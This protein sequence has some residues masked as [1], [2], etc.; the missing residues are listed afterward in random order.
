MRNSQHRQA[1]PA[2]ERR[3][4]LLCQGLLRAARQ[5]PLQAMKTPIFRRRRRYLM[6]S[7]AAIWRRR[8]MRSIAVLI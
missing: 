2:P 7:R 1:S 4:R 5:S 6:P 8:V 3:A